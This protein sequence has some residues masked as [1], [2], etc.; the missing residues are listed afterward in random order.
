MLRKFFSATRWIA[1]H[2]VDVVFGAAVAVFLGWAIRKLGILSF[3]LGENALLGEI[4]D[5]IANNLG[6]TAPFVVAFIW[7]WCVP[8]TLA[9]VGIWAYHTFR[10]K[11][12]NW[13]HKLLGLALATVGGLIL[14][15]GV[16][17]LVNRGTDQAAASTIPTNSSI[18]RRISDIGAPPKLND[19]PPAPKRYTTYEKE[20]RLRAVDEIYSVVA[21]QLQPIQS[22]GHKIIY[23]VYKTADS[24]SEQ[25][26][27]DYVTKVQ[28]AFD[29]LK[30]LLKKYSYFPD[31]VEAATKNK[32]NDVAATHEAGNLV[33]ELQA[34]R[35]KAPNDIQWFL[36][37]DTTMIGAIN[38]IN[39]FE[40][41]LKETLSGLQEKR[42]EIEKAEV[43]SAQ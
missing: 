40:R 38:Q 37:R 8:P 39:D 15:A 42:A 24:D 33:P 41:Y 14:L 4:D 30:A 2:V 18:P 17:L 13:R 19:L 20:Q 3:K 23:G 12:P 10:S 43:Y 36:M 27:T 26:L 22:E 25:H 11:G 29:N 28:A 16:G 21:T 1:K 6:L 5:Q 31:I 35:I 34:L 7:N 9:T 32:F